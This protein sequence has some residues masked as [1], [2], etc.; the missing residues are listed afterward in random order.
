M[1][2][3][4]TTLEDTGGG[5]TGDVTLT[6]TQTLTNKTMSGASNTFSSIPQSAITSLV[7]DLAAKVPSTR[8][9]SV[10]GIS[11][12]LSANRTYTTPF[13]DWVNVK[14]HGA[15]GDGTTS[16]LAA[17]QAALATGKNIFVP[18]GNF[19]IP[20]GGGAGA[21]AITLADNQSVYGTGDRSII[22]IQ[23]NRRG[24]FLA[25]RSVIKGLKFTGSGKTNNQTFEAA[26][27][28]YNKV[29]WTIENCSFNNVSGANTANGGGAIYISATSGAGSFWKNGG[30]IVNCDMQDS[31]VG[32]NNDA[33]GEYLIV[34]GCK[35]T[36]NTTGISMR[37]GNNIF[38][39]C[40]IDENGTGLIQAAGTNDGH[41]GFTECT[42]NHNTT[43]FTISGITQGHR[44]TS[45]TFYQGN[46]TISSSTG[47]RFV[48]CDFG[49]S[50]STQ[51]ITLTS[52][53]NSLRAF[54]RVQT[55]APGTV[56]FSGAGMT[57]VNDLDF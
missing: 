35:I 7:S 46:G 2:N 33:I 31:A 11:Y 19:Y 39:G 48:N 53:T 54:C 17:F 57:A 23:A 44:F 26:I 3:R 49:G 21:T 42:F 8:T 40:N 27:M 16:D 45:C 6:G 15:V 51:T 38:I 20:A 28:A 13:G 32:L 24:F 22:K 41:G 12:D 43:P 14:D 50:A 4:I 47:I 29:N 30:R 9:L 5:G 10:N 18:E 37:G 36:Y 56:T 34:M 25:D 1:A 55:A 52:V